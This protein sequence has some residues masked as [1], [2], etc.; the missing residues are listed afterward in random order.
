MSVCRPQFSDCTDSLYALAK[1]YHLLRLFRVFFAF[2]MSALVLLVLSV[3]VG[4][5]YAASRQT[6]KRLQ[7]TEKSPGNWIPG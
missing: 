6:K 2:F 7:E 5:H 4:T 3:F 1:G